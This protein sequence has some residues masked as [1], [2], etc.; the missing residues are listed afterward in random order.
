MNVKK[1]LSNLIA[2]AMLFVVMTLPS[3]VYATTLQAGQEVYMGIKPLMENSEPYMGYAI[4]NPNNG[5]EKIWNIVRYKSSVASSGYS[6]PNI[7]CVKAGVGFT[8]GVNQIS[9]YNVYFDMKKERSEIAKQ[10][11]I[12]RGL[13]NG[14]LPGNNGATISHIMLF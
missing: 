14:T 11:D 13:V 3:A 8:T 6:N 7:Y 4:N 10:N 5:G 9:P 1:F 2:I 12:L